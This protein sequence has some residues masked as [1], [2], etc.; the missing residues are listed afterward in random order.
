MVNRLQKFLSELCAPHFASH[1]TKSKV[2]RINNQKFKKFVLILNLIQFILNE[3]IEKRAGY[4]FE[5]N[6]REYDLS[7]VKI[8]C[9][10][11]HNF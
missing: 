4:I 1:N 10:M 6:Y 7:F 11:Q 9:K 3:K 8:I 5:Q 2:S